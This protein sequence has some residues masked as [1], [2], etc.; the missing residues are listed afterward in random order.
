DPLVTGV[1][2]CALPI[3]FRP[4][5]SRKHRQLTTRTSLYSRRLSE[6]DAGWLHRLLVAVTRA[7]TASEHNAG[8]EFALLQAWHLYV[9]AETS[10]DRKSVVSGQERDHG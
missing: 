2:T 10:L 8:L 7:Q 4:A 9:D 5:L 3:F 1:Q 6:R